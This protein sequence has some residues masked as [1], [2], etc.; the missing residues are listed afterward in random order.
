MGPA[1]GGPGPPA[2]RRPTRAGRRPSP[3][4]TSV[5]T[6]FRTMWW[7][8]A[9]AEIRTPIRPR[10]ATTPHGPHRQ[11]GSRSRPGAAQ[12]AEKSCFPRSGAARA[13]HRGDV[14]R[15]RRT[16]HA[17]PRRKG[18]GTRSVCQEV[19]VALEAGGPAGVEPLRRGPRGQDPDVPREARVEGGHRDR[20]A[21]AAPGSRRSPP[22]RARGRRRRSGSR[23]PPG[24]HRRTSGRSASRTWPC[25]VGA[26][27]LDLPAVVGRAVV[28]QQE[29]EPRGGRLGIDRPT[30]RASR[31]R[32]A[33][34]SARRWSPRPCGADRPRPRS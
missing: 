12:N 24:R 16:C 34:R 28:G 3:T 6:T 22:G 33:P 15:S 10:R 9:S 14:Q 13:R 25:T 2:P 19:A 4:S 23:R 32:A 7:R 17:N 20:P 8:K 27:G 11:T 18:E 30:G 26:P 31:R 29:R 5:P 1:P 21:R